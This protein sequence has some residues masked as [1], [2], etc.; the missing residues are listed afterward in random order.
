[1]HVPRIARDTVLQLSATIL[2]S[3]GLAPARAAGFKA[4]EARFPLLVTVKSKAIK[5]SH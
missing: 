4:A 1:M 5:S 2:K 3:P